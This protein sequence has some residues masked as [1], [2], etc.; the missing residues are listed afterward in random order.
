MAAQL[1]PLLDRSVVTVSFS[2]GFGLTASQLGVALVRPDHPLRARLATAW[3]WH[4]YYF[5]AL[6]A[7][8]FLALD[9]D[10][11][12]AVDAT[13]RRWV[14]DWLTARGLPDAPG[15][16]YYV[17][18]FRPEGPVPARLAPLVREDVVRLCM[19]PPITR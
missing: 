16:T 10:R 2:R 14:G 19:K 12:Q 1:A 5:N 3:G 17:R 11:V 18:S 8:A 6:A 15:G 9:L 4:S 13:R 7:R